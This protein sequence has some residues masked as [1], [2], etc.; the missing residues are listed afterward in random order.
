M[1]KG[2]S[3]A[4]GVRHRVNN[5]GGDAGGRAGIGG[6]IQRLSAIE[7]WATDDRPVS[8]SLAAARQRALVER[9]SQPTRIRQIQLSVAIVTGLTLDDTAQLT[10]RDLAFLARKLGGRRGAR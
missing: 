5:L 3:H 2:G 6:G 4:G 10:M 9:D 1:S 8:P 7:D